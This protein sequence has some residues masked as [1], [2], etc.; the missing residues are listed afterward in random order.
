M[1]KVFSF[2]KSENFSKEDFVFLPENSLATKSLKDFFAQKEFTKS[3]FPSLI[4]QGEKSSGKSHLLHILAQE[5][6]AKFLNKDQIKKDN[7][8][9]F[10][11]ENAFYIFEDID[12]ISDDE[13]LF[14]LVNSAFEAKAFLIFSLKDFNNFKL[15]DLTS[16]LKN[17]TLCKIEKLQESSLKPLLINGL[18]RRQIK[19]SSTLIDFIILH[20]SR[21]YQE[22]FLVLEKIEKLCHEKKGAVIKEDLKEIF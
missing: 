13:M 20:L 4:L 18:S 21:N 17:I 16:R 10:L 5:N 19:L 22:V 6:L 7:L 8:V 1:Q 2:P 9:K 11:Q 14:H 12:E 3:S 15:K